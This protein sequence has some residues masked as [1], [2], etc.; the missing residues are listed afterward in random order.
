MSFRKRKRIS[1]IFM[2]TLTVSHV[3]RVFFFYLCREVDEK[4][5]Y[6]CCP[7]SG[8]ILAVSVG[9]NNE[10]LIWPTIPPDLWYLRVP[11]GYTAASQNIWRLIILFSKIFKSCI[12]IN[13]LHFWGEGWWGFRLRRHSK[14]AKKENFSCHI[15]SML[16]NFYQ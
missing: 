5:F 12:H 2:F 11:N 16:F 13:T 14:L 8:C 10:Y 4:M 7:Q 15:I 3:K 1:I 9:R 6:F